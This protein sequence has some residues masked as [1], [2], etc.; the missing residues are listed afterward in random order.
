MKGN[1]GQCRMKE[2]LSLYSNQLF[3]QKMFFPETIHENDMKP[4]IRAYF[5]EK[6]NSLDHFHR[7]KRTTPENIEM[8]GQREMVN[9][10][11]HHFF[12]TAEKKPTHNNRNNS[13]ND[14]DHY[15]E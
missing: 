1:F 10:D 7:T 13:S 3:E 5:M 8:G 12:L 4:K 6:G 11:D 2:E 15:F 14:Y 9:S